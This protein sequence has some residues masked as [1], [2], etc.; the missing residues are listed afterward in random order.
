MSTS[1]NEQ[2]DPQNPG[3]G[4]HSA[5][6]FGGAASDAPQYGQQPAAGQYPP[7]G[8]QSYSSTPQYQPAAGQG[9][10]PQQNP[11]QS[12][13][14]VKGTPPLWLGIVVTIAGPVIGILA[15]IISLVS[16]GSTVSEY[17]EAQ[18]GST[19]TLEADQDYW[20]V[21]GDGSTTVSSCTV[22]GPDAGT[23]D[24]NVNPSTSA[25]AQTGDT[26]MNLVATFTS[27]E[28]GDYNVYCSGLMSTDTYVI[29][30]NLG[31]IMAGA[32]GIVGGLLVGG[33]IFVVGIV[34]IIINRVTASRRR[35]AAGIG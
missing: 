27:G 4:Q 25:S 21:S 7:A 2:P 9:G 19:H 11:G 22:S 3:E 6:Q 8:Q 30:A 26:D 24:V 23:V 20:I 28:A 18:P 13:Q 12:G 29:E 35:R 10:Y 5:P 16:L 33:L 14:K 34:L 15:L 32:M 17:A 1:D 31:G